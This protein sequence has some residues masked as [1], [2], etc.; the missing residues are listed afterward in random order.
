MAETEI[1]ALIAR[2]SLLAQAVL[3]T[4][5]IMLFFVIWFILRK[6]KSFRKVSDD[7]NA[8]EDD[9]WGAGKI[10]EIRHLAEEEEYGKDG[11]VAIFLGGMHEYD[12]TKRAGVKDPQL[13]VEGIRRAMESAIQIEIDKLQALL[14]FLATAANSAPFI[15]LFGTVMGIINAFTSL[16][17]SSQATIAQV[18]PGIAEALIATA[19][20]IFCALPAVIAYNHLTAR[21]DRF[22]VQFENF[23][24]HFCNIIRR[25]M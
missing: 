11:L 14:P 13:A 18:A 6:I 20:G 3:L 4:L 15:G 2:A 25:S 24:D 21:L 8:F 16:A 7:S 1:L 10:E 9:F 5:V 12:K 23:S 19:M 22:I 17:N